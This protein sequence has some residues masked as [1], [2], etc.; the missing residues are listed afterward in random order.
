M[1]TK[2]AFGRLQNHL[3]RQGSTDGG[4]KIWE[5]CE[6]VLVAGS[7]GGSDRCLMRKRVEAVVYQLEDKVGVIERFVQDGAMLTE[8]TVRGIHFVQDS[9]DGIGRAIAGGMGALG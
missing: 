3:A 1:P 4:A 2:R 9:P 5:R 7:E 6:F 8:K